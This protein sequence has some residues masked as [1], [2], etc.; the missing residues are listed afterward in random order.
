[1]PLFGPGRWMTG[2]NWVIDG[3]CRQGK[4]LG[5]VFP[6]GGG[7]IFGGAWPAHR[8]LIGDGVIALFIVVLVGIRLVARRTRFVSEVSLGTS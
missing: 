1:L 5:G 8:P 4:D 2:P 6:I 7:M 3:I